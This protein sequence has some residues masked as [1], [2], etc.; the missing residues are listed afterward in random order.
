MFLLIGVFVYLVL[1]VIGFLR[2]VGLDVVFLL[3]I[4][5]YMVL[6]IVL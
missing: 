5:D 2:A 4:L 3:H 1:F 6:F